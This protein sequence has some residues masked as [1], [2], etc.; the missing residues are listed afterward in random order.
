MT[1]LNSKI[2]LLFSGLLLTGLIQVSA[3]SDEGDL[4]DIEVVIRKDKDIVLPRANRNY[5]KI[6]DI[7]KRE[8]KPGS[9]I[10]FGDYNVA[11]SPLDPSIRINK[12]S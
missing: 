5:Q 12:L 11:L 10:N 9:E 1:V 8:F 3:Q 2:L 6:K 7:P 4:E